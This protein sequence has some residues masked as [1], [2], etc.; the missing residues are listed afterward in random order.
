M[1]EIILVIQKGPY[2]RET[3]DGYLPLDEEKAL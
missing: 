2:K 1:W 3:D